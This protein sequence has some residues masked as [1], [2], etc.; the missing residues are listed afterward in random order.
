ME[1]IKT[2]DYINE[3]LADN[4]GA[5]KLRPQF[6]DAIAQLMAAL[7][8]NGFSIREE[9]GHVFDSQYTR[10]PCINMQMMSPDDQTVL[11]ITVEDF[12]S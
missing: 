1:T 2:T 8:N 9:Y 5:E 7:E 10:R 12:G 3:A 4:E 11:S 6:S